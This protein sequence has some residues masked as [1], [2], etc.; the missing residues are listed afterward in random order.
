M[1]S[2]GAQPTN[3]ICE[4]QGKL[5]TYTTNQYLIRNGDY[6]FNLQNPTDA[7]MSVNPEFDE[8]NFYYSAMVGQDFGYNT[9]L[10]GYIAGKFNFFFNDRI[11]GSIP[12]SRA[13]STYTGAGVFFDGTGNLANCGVGVGPAEQLPAYTIGANNGGFAQAQSL[14]SLN[15]DP[16]ALSHLPGTTRYGNIRIN[17]QG[18]VSFSGCNGG[19]QFYY[20]PFLPLDGGET[21][22]GVNPA[23]GWADIWGGDY[24][25]VQ[26]FTPPFF[27]RNRFDAVKVELTHISVN[28]IAAKIFMGILSKKST[29]NHYGRQQFQ[30]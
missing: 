19:S 14:A 15:C 25:G 22:G 20:L 26:M 21:V 18:N 11:V 8:H 23:L 1:Q 12:F 27:L 6:T 3:S 17:Q 7:E 5:L 16:E 2:F 30:D 29:P 9:R 13:C 4:A 28:T 10:A 24:A